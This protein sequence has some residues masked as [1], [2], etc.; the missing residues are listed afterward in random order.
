MKK[1]LSILFSLIVII[2]VAL[3]AASCTI[4]V[5]GPASSGAQGDSSKAVSEAQGGD[6]SGS[7]SQPETGESSAEPPE[8]ESSEPEESSKPAA[9]TDADV[10]KIYAAAIQKTSEPE[11]IHMITSIDQDMSI[12]IEGLSAA[13]TRNSSGRVDDMILCGRH[14]GNIQMELHETVKGDV[15]SD[16]D[17]FADENNFYIRQSG[18]ESY[19]TLARNSSQAASLESLMSE[20][21]TL[22]IALP[23]SV[24]KNASVKTG[25][26]VTEISID[27]DPG[28][29]QDYF[30][31]TVD[32]YR[33]IFAQMGATGV[34]VSVKSAQY[35]FVIDE[36][37]YITKVDLTID[38]AMTMTI[39]GYKA[40][41]EITGVTEAE[42]IDPGKSFIINFPSV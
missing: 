15:S 13:P 42:I 2:A 16:I 19:T 31:S 6:S 33:E 21:N 3:S 35:T 9:L 27:P 4:V 11:D 17:V 38:M 7:V 22:M 12:T 8:A 1:P 5:D 18:T 30:A 40:N 39:Y 37:G 10:Y 25:N 28:Y 14:S 23:E 20:D 32:Q 29:M 41:A 34:T 26:G 24:F 36:N